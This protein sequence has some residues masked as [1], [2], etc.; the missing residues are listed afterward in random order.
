MV[1]II[2]QI[3]TF[4]LKKSDQKQFYLC[5][6]E[7]KKCVMLYI[8]DNFE[9]LKNWITYNNM[10]YFHCFKFVAKFSLKFEEQYLK[11]AECNLNSNNEC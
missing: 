6:S 7:L 5:R 4:D 11:L 2:S 3:N 10:G 8:C 9:H 1:S